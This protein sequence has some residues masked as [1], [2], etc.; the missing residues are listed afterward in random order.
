[1]RNL[2]CFFDFKPVFL[3]LMNLVNRVECRLLETK[4]NKEN[5]FPCFTMFTK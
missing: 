1:M 2:L 5:I 3:I 4:M